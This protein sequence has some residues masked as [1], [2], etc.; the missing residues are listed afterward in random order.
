MGGLSSGACES[1]T[2]QF[3]STEFDWRYLWV[4]YRPGLFT[5]EDYTFTPA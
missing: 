4:L 1:E 5:S 2:G 3:G